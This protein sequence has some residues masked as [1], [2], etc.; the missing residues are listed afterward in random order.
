[1]IYAGQLRDL[2]ELA[3]DLYERSKGPHLLDGEYGL[4][5]TLVLSAIHCENEVVLDYR[6]SGNMVNMLRNLGFVVEVLDNYTT[7]VSW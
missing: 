6:C 2:T 1:M 3:K 7:K 4:L 5:H